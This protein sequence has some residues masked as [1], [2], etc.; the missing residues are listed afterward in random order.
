M[1][2]DVLTLAEAADVLKV[3]AKTVTRLALDGKIR[4]LL[5]GKQYRFRRSWI[6]AFIDRNEDSNA[7]EM[8]AVKPVMTARIG[9][10]RG[11]RTR[12]SVASPAAQ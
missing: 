3:S 11:G 2:T 4:Y 9:Q 1:T 8:V 12:P 6:D 7:A 10:L 5:V